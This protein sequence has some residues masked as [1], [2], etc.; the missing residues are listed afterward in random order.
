MYI[1][2]ISVENYR[3]I[4]NNPPLK[5]KLGNLTVISGANDSGKTSFLISSYIGAFL[6]NGVSFNK[7]TYIK[8]LSS[9]E[10]SRFFDEEK[11]PLDTEQLVTFAIKLH[12]SEVN[13]I[14]KYIFKNE[15]IQSSSSLLNSGNKEFSEETLRQ[16]FESNNMF[17][18]VSL[19]STA[20]Y[21]FSEMIDFSDFSSSIFDFFG[22]EEASDLRAF[23][24][25]FLEL[26]IKALNLSTKVTSLTTLFVPSQTRDKLFNYNLEEHDNDN[27]ITSELITFFKDLRTEKRRRNGDY[28]K[29]IKY[30]K[31]VF[32]ELQSIDIGNPVDGFIEEDL[33]ITWKKNGRN[34]YQPLNRSGTGITNIIYIISKLL[35][36]YTDMNIVFIDEPENGLHPKLQVRFMRLLKQLSKEFNVQWIISTHS[37]FIMQKLKD[38]DKLY[39]LEH[40]GT[41]TVGRAIDPGRKEDVFYALG[42]YLPLTLAANGIIFVE[43]RTEVTVLSILLNKVGID[44]EKDNILLIPLGGENLF[45]IEPIDIKKIHDK[46][47]VIIDSDLQKSEKQGGNIKQVKLNYEKACNEADLKCLLIREYRTIENMYPKEILSKVLNKQNVLEHD[48]FGSIS[49]IPDRKKVSI[50]EQV[51]E[52]MS[53][54]QAEQFPLI[55]EILNWWNN[56]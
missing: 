34:H 50:G 31:D 17:F 26:I 39:L 37:P 19:N 14:I 33:F 21:S 1:E 13:T 46:S 43:G 44:I 36:S 4:G 6:M 23:P 47:M 12:S 38:E 3:S 24:R 49:D 32:P 42:A 29:F 15:A 9:L 41:S 45:N 7:D 22:F 10:G 54:E 28:T 55:K 11:G 16:Y 2:S 40:N 48:N 30:C 56:N 35:R 27:V 53:R 5:V 25:Y 8:R 51:A 20:S 52:E 18:K